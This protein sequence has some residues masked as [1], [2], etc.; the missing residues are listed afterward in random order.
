M[1]AAGSERSAQL[2]VPVERR[3]NRITLEPLRR[4]GPDSLRIQ[5]IS[6][7]LK[8]TL[9]TVEISWH[10]LA[11]IIITITAD[12]V[13]EFVDL[14]GTVAEPIPRLRTITA[15]TFFVQF[16]TDP[17]PQTVTLRTPGTL[18]IS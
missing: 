16:T 8:I 10:T 1:P 17:V 6:E 7:L 15:A 18:L 12:D 2:Q 3:P 5:G 4:D 14:D 11:H 9:C 13:F